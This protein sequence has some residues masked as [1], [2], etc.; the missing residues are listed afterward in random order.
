MHNDPYAGASHG[1]DVAFIVPVF[2]QGK[3]IGFAATTA[4][5][6]DIGALSPGS[7]RHRRGDRR[8]CRG[9]A[10]QGDQGLRPRREERHG[11]ADRARQHP[12]LRP[13]GRRHG[14]PGRRRA[15][16]RRAH[17]R[18]GR[19]L[20]P[21]DLRPRLRRAD[22]PC[23]AAD[24]PGD[25]Q[26]AR[27]RLSRRDGDRRLSRQRRSRARRSCRSSS[28]SPRRTTA[29]SSTSP[30]PRRRCPTGRSTCR[31]K[32]PSTSRS[33]SPSARC[34]STRDDPRPHPGQN[35]GLIRPITIVAPKGCLANPTFPAPTIARFC[36]GNQLADTVMKALSAGHAGQR[37]GRHRQPQGHRL[38]RPQ[39]RDALGAHGDLRGLLRRPAGQGRHGRRRHA[40]RQH[41]QQPDRGHRDPPAACACCATSCARTWPAPASGAAAWARCASSPS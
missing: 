15:H 11:L 22:G 26:A 1:P 12:R 35:A 36:P 2:V 38:L 37:L 20:R 17:G 18:A 25:R 27:R 39:G 23:R 29:S 31:S 34:C 30:A 28:P 19:A 13:R 5:H 6:L 32:A 24:A 16:R 7:V 3:L 21:R 4:H 33:G 41:P 40:L 14:R 9:P 8:L 10:V